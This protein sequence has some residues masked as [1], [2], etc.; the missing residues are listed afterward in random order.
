MVVKQRLKI[1]ETQSPRH[2][3]SIFEQARHNRH[4][5]N[6]VTHYSNYPDADMTFVYIC[7]QTL[8]K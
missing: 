5:T 7:F 1:S 8:E 6:Y 3:K 4:F 2:V